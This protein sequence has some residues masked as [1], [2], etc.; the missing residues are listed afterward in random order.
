LAVAAALLL[1]PAPVR[2]Q[3]LAPLP[4]LATG[5]VVAKNTA[6]I[7]AKVVSYVKRIGGDVGATV[8][9]GE[10]LI[11]LDD[12][13]FAANVALAQA[14]LADA[15]ARLGLAEKSFHRMRSLL[16]KGATTQSA[17]DEA[18]AGYAQAQA[19]VGVAEAELAKAKVFLGY[20]LLR[21]PFAGTVEF[22]RIE[23]GELTAPGQPLM[24]VTDVARLRFETSVKESDVNRIAVGGEA[25]ILVDALPG[26][27]VSGTVAHIVPSGE[28]A[29]HSFIVRID[30]APTEGLKPGMYGKARWR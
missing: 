9:K 10:V 30:L 22:K 20:T 21:A 12:G 24:K 4:V 26:V 7:A 15:R 6:V 27:E 8:K 2:A 18:S 16:E 25:T 13:E 23:V 5:T 17:F 3:E 14:H 11:Q 28:A 19:G 29:T 1:F